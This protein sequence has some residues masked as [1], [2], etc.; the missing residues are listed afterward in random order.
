MA[1][2]EY[3]SISCWRAW[4][5]TTDYSYLVMWAALLRFSMFA[6]CSKLCSNFSLLTHWSSWH[7]TKCCQNMSVK[8]KIS[9]G[10]EEWSVVDSFIFVFFLLSLLYS[11]HWAR[12]KRTNQTCHK[13]RLMPIAYNKTSLFK[14]SRHQTECK[15]IKLLQSECE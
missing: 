5:P 1:S 9:L 2:F 3:S 11:S 8:W 12:Q 4:G 14:L 6:L 10:P 15:L 7:L 13:S